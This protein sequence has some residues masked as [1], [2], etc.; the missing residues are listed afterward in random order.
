MNFFS[1]LNSFIQN[2]TVYL[3]VCNFAVAVQ[4]VL[5]CTSEESHDFEQIKIAHNEL[6]DCVQACNAR[7]RRLEDL[8]ML[9]K[10]D[11]QMDYSRLQ[12]HASL[13]QPLVLI[14][15]IFVNGY[16]VVNRA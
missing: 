1:Q 12:Q 7:L 16:F 2:I 14:Y 8:S 13:V 4:A 3:I 15:W 5:N 9:Q 10:L 11:A 6:T